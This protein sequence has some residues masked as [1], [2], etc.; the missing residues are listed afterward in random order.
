[1]TETQ[2]FSWADF[3][4]HRVQF[5]DPNDAVADFHRTGTL[6]TFDSENN[7]LII[8]DDDGNEFFIP[9]DHA[10]TY[11]TLYFEAQL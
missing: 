2:F 3:V 1:M 11:I 6:R 8:Q 7:L 5:S 10:F 9:L 4:D